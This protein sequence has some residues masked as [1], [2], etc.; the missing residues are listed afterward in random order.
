MKRWLVISLVALASLCLLCTGGALLLGLADDD[1]AAAGP[2]TSACP[3]SYQGWRQDVGERGLVFTQEGT[4]LVVEQAWPF[5][6]TDALRQGDSE[7]NVWRAVLGERYEP[8][9]FTRAGYGERRLAGPATERASGRTVFIAFTS[10]AQGGI[11]NPVAAIA[12]DEATLQASFPTE[13]SLVATQQLNRFSLG[14]APVAGRWKSG[15]STAAERYAVGTGRFLGVEA[16][17]AWRDMTLT[18][19]GSYER[20][21]NAL[22]NGVYSKQHDSGSWSNDAWSLVLSPESGE[23]TTYDAALVRVRSGFLLKLTNRKF[24]GDSE[25]FQRVE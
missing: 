2:G 14:C 23:A 1:G 4:G 12:A 3:S 9:R 24:S 21:S 13:G 18:P 20:E 25:E 10:G 15:F 8:Q 7:E 19:G 6:L 22:A 17:A 16:V 5:E 11:A